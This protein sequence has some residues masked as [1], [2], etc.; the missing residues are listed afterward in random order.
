MPIL[1][2]QVIQSLDVGERF[3]A[4]I[5]DFIVDYESRSS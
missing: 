1:Q 5:I 4:S 3:T 2:K